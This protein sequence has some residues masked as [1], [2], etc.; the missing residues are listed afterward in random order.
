MRRVLI[1]EDDSREIASARNA[2]LQGGLFPHCVG[3][4][5]EA[6]S[7][8]VKDNYSHI[9]MEPCVKGLNLPL[10][11]SLANKQEAAIVVVTSDSSLSSERKLRQMGIFYYMVKPIDPLELG[12]VLDSSNEVRQRSPQP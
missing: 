10:L 4:G 9:V 3:T 7:Y 8:L 6:I 5:E 11:I 12:L 2:A 1:I